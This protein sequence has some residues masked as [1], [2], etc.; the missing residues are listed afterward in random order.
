[1]FFSCQLWQLV[2]FSFSLRKK[3]FAYFTF[4]SSLIFVF[5][6]PLT[7]HFVHMML[8]RDERFV[9]FLYMIWKLI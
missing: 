2:S 9:Y 3:N 5:F 6:I 4:D 1:M 8:D 7:N